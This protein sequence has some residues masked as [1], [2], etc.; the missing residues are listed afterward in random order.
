MMRFSMIV[1][2]VFVQTNQRKNRT[3]RICKEGLSET[4]TREIYGGGGGGGATYV[5]KVNNHKDN[6]NLILK[7]CN[8]SK[9]QKL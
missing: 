8:A 4:D 9:V 2:L 7:L 6:L 3:A 5:F 1:C